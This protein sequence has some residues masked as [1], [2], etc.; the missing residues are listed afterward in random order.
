MGAV[1]AATSVNKKACLVWGVPSSVSAERILTKVR[2]KTTK[3]EEI[4][5]KGLSNRLEQNQPELSQRRGNSRS[6]LAPERWARSGWWAKPPRS[7]WCA[8]KVWMMETDG[9]HSDCLNIPPGNSSTFSQAHWSCPHGLCVLEYCWSVL[10]CACSYLLC[11]I[12]FLHS[13]CWITLFKTSGCISCFLSNIWAVES[14]Q[15]KNR[16]LEI[17]H[18]IRIFKYSTKSTILQRIS[19]TRNYFYFC[20]I[21][22]QTF[23]ETKRCNTLI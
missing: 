12:C 3:P 10:R 23:L 14:L 8:V 6:G 13:A 15:Q 4:S 22:K 21:K 19:I 17:E 16:W 9:L 11:T 5:A 18:W 2:L 20:S 1:Q 7:A